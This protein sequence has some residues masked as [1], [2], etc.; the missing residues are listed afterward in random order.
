LIID[1]SVVDSG[2]YTHTFETWRNKIQ[3]VKI[4]MPNLY[5]I[6]QRGV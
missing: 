2:E 6:F 4:K 1:I 5:H 3:Y